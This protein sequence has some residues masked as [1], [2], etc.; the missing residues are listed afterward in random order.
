MATLLECA[1]CF[2]SYV[3]PAQDSRGARACPWCGAQTE[4]ELLSGDANPTS[5]VDQAAARRANFRPAPPYGNSRSLWKL[6][7]YGASESVHRQSDAF[8]HR[9]LDRNRA[10][11]TAATT[12]S[13]ASAPE[14]EPASALAPFPSLAPSRFPRRRRGTPE[15]VWMFVGIGLGACVVLAVLAVALPGLF[16]QA[17]RSDEGPNDSLAQPAATAPDRTTAHHQTKRI[18]LPQSEHDNPRDVV[19]SI[20]SQREMLRQLL[21]EEMSRADAESDTAAPEPAESPRWL[22]SRPPPI[23]DPEDDSPGIGLVLPERVAKNRTP[24]ATAT[25]RPPTPREPPPPEP[26]KDD[27]GA[28]AALAAAGIRTEKGTDSGLV[29]RLDGS[30]RMTDAMMPHVAKL[31]GLV[32]L[33]LSFSDITDAGLANLKN[34]SALKELILNET[35]VT[36]AGLAHLA[37]LAALEKLDLEKTRVTDAAIAELKSLKNL[38]QLDVRNTKVTPPAVT[39]LRESLPDARIRN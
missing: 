15:L 24:A 16:R 4:P 14:V 23:G 11:P 1:S 22:S 5:A 29:A 10:T 7:G 3:V 18:R 30:F 32:Y 27:A 26:V 6:T 9:S 31:P 34:A 8:A 36:D 33:K 28:I 38:K 37:G 21:R 25:S 12:G 20:T 17:A 39:E 2:Q 19:R 13:D 35:A